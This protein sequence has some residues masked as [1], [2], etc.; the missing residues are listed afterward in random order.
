LHGAY[1][2]GGF[3]PKVA[4]TTGPKSITKKKIKKST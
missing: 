1:Q 3:T 4:V 2:V